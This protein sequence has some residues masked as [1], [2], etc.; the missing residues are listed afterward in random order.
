MRAVVSFITMSSTLSTKPRSSR[1][2]SAFFSKVA[3]TPA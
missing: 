1:Q 2:S 3:R